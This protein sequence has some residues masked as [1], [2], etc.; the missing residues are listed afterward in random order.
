[1]VIRKEHTCEYE[2]EVIR[3][4]IFEVEIPKS[5]HSKGKEVVGGDRVNIEL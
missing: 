4:V 3:G 5:T 2:G 1:M